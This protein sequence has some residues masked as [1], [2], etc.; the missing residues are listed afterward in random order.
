M[1]VESPTTMSSAEIVALNRAHTFF[2]W[3]IQG[4]RDPIASDHADEIFQE[5]GQAGIFV[6][7]FSDHADWLRFGIPGDEE[8]WAR[9][10]RALKAG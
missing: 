3:S 7:R 6:R 1:A 4:A 5:L 9:L 10:T 2:S 8:E